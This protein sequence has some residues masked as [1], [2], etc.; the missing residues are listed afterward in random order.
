MTTTPPTGKGCTPMSKFQKL[1]LGEVEEIEDITGTTLAH[2][3]SRPEEIPAKAVA[4]IA[5]VI[6]RRTDP[7]ITIEATRALDYEEVLEVFSG[8]MGEELGKAPAAP[9]TLAPPAPP[10]GQPSSDGTSSSASATSTAG[11]PQESAA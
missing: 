8:A 3:F 6:L 11:P 4:A 5:Y 9:P 7:T 2:L 1:T 10:A